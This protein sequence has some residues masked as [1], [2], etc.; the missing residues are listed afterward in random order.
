MADCGICF[1][2]ID[3]NHKPWCARSDAVTIP[4]GPWIEEAACLPNFLEL[5]E[6]QQKGICAACPVVAPCLTHSVDN[7]EADHVWGGATRLERASIR[8]AGNRTKAIR[9]HLAGIKALAFSA[10]HLLLV[11]FFGRTN[12]TPVTRFAGAAA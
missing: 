6:K 10:S 12:Y 8:A 11:V 2:A 1:T 9:K 7:D 3:S 5:T 4:L